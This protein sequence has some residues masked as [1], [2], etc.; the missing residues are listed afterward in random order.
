MRS[1]ARRRPSPSMLVALLALFVALG[2]TSYAALTITG[3]NV[4]NGSLTGKTSRT[5]RSP[6]PT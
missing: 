6:A 3:K 2:G 4:R 5:T 1:L